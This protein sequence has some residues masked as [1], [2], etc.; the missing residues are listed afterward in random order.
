VSREEGSWVALAQATCP[1]CGKVFD[2]GEVLLDK[3]VRPVFKK[4]HAMVGW[5]LCPEDK[6]R[7]DAGMIALI[8][9]DEGRSEKLPNGNMEPEGAH[10][11]GRLMHI[12]VEAWGGVFNVDPPKDGLAFCEDAVIDTLAGMYKEATGKYPDGYTG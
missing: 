5:Q 3:R 11:T 8:G 4:K 9:C 10:R 12:K 2:T 6:A 7:K 1:V